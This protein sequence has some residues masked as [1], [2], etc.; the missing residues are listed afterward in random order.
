MASFK[1][2]VLGMYLDQCVARGRQSSLGDD[3]GRST[4]RPPPAARTP[5]RGRSSPRS[6]RHQEKYKKT[7][8][9]RA[10]ENYSTSQLDAL[11]AKKTKQLESEK[12]S[13]KETGMNV[14]KQKIDST[15]SYLDDLRTI[16]S[17]RGTDS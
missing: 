5:T 7:S 2:E 17:E 16:R 10:E 9:R 4:S 8:G 13:Y 12:R 3:I 6:E 1:Q 11:I 15:S 14:T